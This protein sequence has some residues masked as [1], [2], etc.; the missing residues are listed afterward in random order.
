M[1][2]IEEQAESLRKDEAAIR[3]AKLWGSN[4]KEMTIEESFDL[5]NNLYD[6]QQAIIKSHED[7][8]TLAFGI[9]SF[10]N[11]ERITL[12]SETWRIEPL[13]PR[14]STPFFRSL[15]PGFQIPLPSVW[16]SRDSGGPFG[17]QLTKHMRPWDEAGEKW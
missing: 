3:K 2:A 14:F 8:E 11:L 9:A 12:S 16:T 17:Y 4:P 10:L 6:E 1:K 13:F 7:S 5:H 15:P